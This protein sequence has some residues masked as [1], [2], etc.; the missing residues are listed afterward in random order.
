MR[1]LCTNVAICVYKIKAY[2]SSLNLRTSG[3]LC[4]NTKVTLALF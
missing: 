3:G 1:A 4:V 2:V